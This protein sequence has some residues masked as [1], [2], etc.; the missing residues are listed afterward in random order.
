MARFH[1]P[2][3][4]NNDTNIALANIL[5]DNNDDIEKFLYEH[6]ERKYYLWHKFQR[7]SKPEKYTHEDL[8]YAVKIL[9][10]R[11]QVQISF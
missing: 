11:G 2:P 6:T 7:I 4:S 1:K 8:W 3:K 9:R 5:I 10:S